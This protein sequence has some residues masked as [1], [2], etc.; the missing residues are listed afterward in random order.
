MS[1]NSNNI[2]GEILMDL[3][4]GLSELSEAERIERKNQM[5]VENALTK[6]FSDSFR[7]DRF[8]R[9]NR[10]FLKITCYDDI[11]KMSKW[12]RERVLSEIHRLN[13]EY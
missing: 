3:A 9:K 13:G 12:D 10:L 2:F 11:E 5:R 6:Y 4:K 1:K 8:N 7:R